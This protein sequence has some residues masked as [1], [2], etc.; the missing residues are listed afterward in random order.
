LTVFQVYAGKQTG[1]QRRH[2]LAM[3]APFG[4]TEHRLPE[5]SDVMD[6]VFEP[7]HAE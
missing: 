6:G 5:I 3:F 2:V 1:N 7:E 4:S